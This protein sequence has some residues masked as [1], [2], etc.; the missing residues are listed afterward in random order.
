[1]D[2]EVVHQIFIVGHRVDGYSNIEY[3]FS[4]ISALVCIRDSPLQDDIMPLSEMPAS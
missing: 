4:P 1:M 3:A 2:F